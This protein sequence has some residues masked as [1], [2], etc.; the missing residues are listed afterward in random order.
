MPQSISPSRF[1]AQ[2]NSAAVLPYTHCNEYRANDSENHLLPNVSCGSENNRKLRLFSLFDNHYG[3][4][5][6]RS[7]CS[8][9]PPISHIKYVGQRVKKNKGAGG[10]DGMKA[11]ELL[12]RCAEKMR[13]WLREHPVPVVR[14]PDALRLMRQVDACEEK[15]AH[16]GADP[17]D[18]HEVG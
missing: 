16:G 10:V 9:A 15:R 18:A 8:A 11:D 6:R 5:R 2:Q 1:A 4:G 13:L 7:K 14:L 17:G 12:P 3:K